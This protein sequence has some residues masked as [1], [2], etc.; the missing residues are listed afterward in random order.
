MSSPGK[1]GMSTRALVGDWA[2][3]RCGED[4]WQWPGD[5]Q[6]A[7]GLLAAV[8]LQSGP[9]WGQFALR[10]LTFSTLSFSFTGSERC[11]LP[12]PVIVMSDAAARLS[13]LRLPP[14][15]HS[16]K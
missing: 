10:Q 15:M 12:D 6:Q 3:D 4:R 16:S 8:L 11:A 14:V 13:M 2:L 7:D 5:F 1:S 9:G